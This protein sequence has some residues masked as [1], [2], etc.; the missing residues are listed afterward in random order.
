MKK[1]S[2]TYHETVQEAIAIALL[3]HL[4]TKSLSQISISD[5]TQTAGV[6]RSS[7]YRNFDS[8]EEVLSQYIQKCYKE[9]FAEEK[10]Q[11]QKDQDFDLN[12]FLY[13]RF[14]FIKQHRDIFTILR[15]HH[16]LYYIFE[17]LDP[18]LA[19]VLSGMKLSSPYYMAMFASCSAG[20]IRQW[21]D[22]DFKESEEE[23]IEIHLSLSKKLN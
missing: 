20:I 3:K 8:K 5:I 22:N 11:N 7:F 16:L 17:A 21:I 14:H 13:Q 9:Y 18:E 12:L 2:V 6:H 19:E 1:H 23:M 10:I 15:K 4:K